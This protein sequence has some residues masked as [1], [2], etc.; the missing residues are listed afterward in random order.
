MMHFGRETRVKLIGG[1]LIYM[2]PFEEIATLRARVEG[3]QRRA[4]NL[5]PVFEAF[6]SRWQEL[7]RRNFVRE[8]LPVPWPALSPAY[9]EW[10]SRY[11]PGKTILRR[12]DRLF[13][14]LVTSNGDAIWEATPRTIRFGTR[15]PW[16]GFHQR[17]TDSMPARLPLIMLPDTFAELNSRTMAYVTRGVIHG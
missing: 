12:T 17:G 8:G 5:K 6:R 15:V 16:F 1:E 13:N 9:A 7:I 4:T 2:A 14:S 3:M 10:K 11:F